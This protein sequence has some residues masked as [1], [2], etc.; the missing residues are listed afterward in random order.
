MAGIRFGQPVTTIAGPRDGLT[1]TLLNFAR[2]VSPCSRIID[3]E[4]RRSDPRTHTA[5]AGLAGCK[6]SMR[7]VVLLAV[8]AGLLQAQKPVVALGPAEVINHRSL[9]ITASS[10]RIEARALPGGQRLWE[11]DRPAR[12][13]GVLDAKPVG[14]TGCEAGGHPAWCVAVFD[15]AK[16]RQ[17]Q[18]HAQSQPLPLSDFVPP[19]AAGPGWDR[20]GHIY[21]ALG[22]D[23]YIVA[24]GGQGGLFPVAWRASWR[25]SGGAV[26]PQSMETRRESAGVFTVAFPQGTV[27]A[28]P[29][30][31]SNSRFATRPDRYT[32]PLAHCEVITGNKDRVDAWLWR[33]T[34]S[35][36]CQPVANGRRWEIALEPILIREHPPR[37]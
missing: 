33:H 32:G 17:G 25:Y 14:L 2:W 34:V 8:A 31:L 16:G 4:H 1:R 26:P 11:S 18:I 28:S 30:V 10:S 24:L 6:C 7:S 13:I 22:A 35:V 19:F 12:L 20:L 9:Y 3:G 36:A 21:Q 29:D 23:L 37:P 5:S 27:T 15:T